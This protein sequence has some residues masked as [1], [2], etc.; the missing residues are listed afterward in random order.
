MAY[1]E[2]KGLNMTI[3]N[4]HIANVYR[5]ERVANHQ[6]MI[7]R[8]GAKA[9]IDNTDPKQSTGPV[10]MSKKAWLLEQQ[11]ARIE[12]DNV[13]ILRK[14]H[15]ILNKPAE[16]SRLERHGPRSMNIASRRKE[17]ERIATENQVR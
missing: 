14:M 2:R 9:A 7:R 13:A 6:M 11:Y 10:N 16:F 17:L 5:E 15:D 8:G 3:G 12:Q 1:M 4:T